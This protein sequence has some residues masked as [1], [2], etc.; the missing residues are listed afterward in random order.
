MRSGKLR[1]IQSGFQRE[2]SVA[3]E[4]G[5]GRKPLPCGSRLGE[6]KTAAHGTVRHARREY[7]LTA[8]HGSR[9]M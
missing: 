5:A 2:R 6:G 9:E 1:S 8:T 7:T 3:G 4:R